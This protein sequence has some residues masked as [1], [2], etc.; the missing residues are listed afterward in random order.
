MGLSAELEGPAAIVPAGPH[1]EV[2]AAVGQRTHL[3]HC[4][5]DN[6]DNNNNHDRHQ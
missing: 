4:N 1:G 2:V 3:V 5:N 6:N